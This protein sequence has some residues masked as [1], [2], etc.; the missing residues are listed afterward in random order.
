MK[1]EKTCCLTGLRA[2][3]LPFRFCEE[4]PC[5][6]RL[7]ERLRQ[8]IIRS[9]TQDNVTHFMTGMSLGSEQICAEI[10]LEI[11]NDI[12]S[13]TLECVIPYEK[14]SAKWLA[15]QRHRYDKILAASDKITLLQTIYSRD[16]MIKRN[17]YITENCDFVIAVWDGDRS[18]A[19]GQL[20]RSARAL[21]RTVMIL[22]PRSFDLAEL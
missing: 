16:C 8:E 14:Q 20:I 10:V 6:L 18:N 1:K 13:I 7:K 22:D 21:G 11:K 5:C 15:P 17:H 19:V 3:R 12:P 9:I 4:H 2:Q